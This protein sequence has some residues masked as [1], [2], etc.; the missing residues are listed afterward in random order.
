MKW[1]VIIISFYWIDLKMVNM[2]FRCQICEILL[3]ALFRSGAV[4]TQTKQILNFELCSLPCF[5]MHRYARG[6]LFGKMVLELGDV[7]QVTNHKLETSCEV[8]FKTKGFFSG[9]YNSIHGKVRSHKDEI[10]E[11]SGK[12]SDQMYFQRHKVGLNI[13]HMIESTNQVFAHLPTGSERAI[14][15]CGQGGCS[16]ERGCARI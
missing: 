8:D 7:A 15:R 10:G 4:H 1:V 16:A 12:W 14:L 13:G 6:I 2:I 9:S 3:S 5:H 11:I